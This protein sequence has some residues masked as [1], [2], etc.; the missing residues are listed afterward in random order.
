VRIAIVTETWLPS[1]NGVVTRLVATVRELRARGHEVLVIC[2][3][4]GGP[5]GAAVCPEGTI[6][7]P[8]PSVGLP[9]IYGGMPWGLP[10]PRVVRALD[11]F[12]P[13]LVHAVCPFILGWA[14]VLFARTRGKP[15]VCSYH[16][17]IARYARFYHFGFAERPVWAVVR[18]LHQ[19]AHVN[20]TVSE[21]SRLELEG[22]GVPHVAIW[23]GGVDLD[24]FRPDRADRAMRERLTGGH[25][26][27]RICLYVGRLAAEKAL[28]ELLPLAA[29]GG[30]RHVALVGDGPARS[31]LAQAFQGSQ[32]TL[33]GPMSGIE[34]AAAFASADVFTFPST[35]DTLGLVLLEAMASGLPVVA[36][37]TPGAEELISRAPAGSLFQ[38]GDRE[39]LTAAVDL[40]LESPVD[41]HALAAAARDQIGG[42]RRSTDDLLIQYQ[43][44]LAQVS[45]SLAA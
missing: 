22:Q 34:L 4:V 14:G 27:R 40:W 6:V 36:A 23:R 37:R 20:L 24:L 18:K 41:P 28:D 7:R 38:L 35:T 44:A 16:T 12:R 29:P 10:L 8:V 3:T 2:P 17:H 42:W 31:D 26:E 21:A 45:G 32:A 30:D 39:E 5:P 33:T 11:R 1:I 13:D 9:F 15:L 25:P 43:R 19:Q